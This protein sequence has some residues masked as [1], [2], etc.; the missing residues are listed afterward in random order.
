[1]TVFSHP[2]GAE[3]TDGWLLMANPQS[4]LP[5]SYEFLKAI[6][7]TGKPIVTIG[8]RE[9]AIACHSVVIN[10]RQAAKDAVLHLI[11]DHGHRRVAFVGSTEHVDLLERFEGYVE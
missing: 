11:R 7:R 5:S 4:V 10:N 2:V 8:Y 3:S 1:P 9:N 6:E